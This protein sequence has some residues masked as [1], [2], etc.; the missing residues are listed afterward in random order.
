MPG[1]D[2][3]LARPV[4]CFQRLEG[5]QDASYIHQQ[6]QQRAE[7]QSE[8]VLFLVNCPYLRFGKKT[9]L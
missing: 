4:R 1:D 9:K 5:R 6:P 3:P 7:S 8:R 2:A